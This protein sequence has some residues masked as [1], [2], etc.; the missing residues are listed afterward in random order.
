MIASSSASTS[1]AATGR[2]ASWRGAAAACRGAW[3]RAAARERATGRR[4]RSTAPPAPAPGGRRSGPRMPRRRHDEPSTHAQTARYCRQRA[5]V[6][7]LGGRAAERE[8]A[9]VPAPGDLPEDAVGRRRARLDDA[10]ARQVA[11]DRAHD[12]L[13]AARVPRERLR[14][15]VVAAAVVGRAGD[16]A[17]DRLERGLLD[18]RALD[19]EDVQALVA[20]RREQQAARGRPVAAR[21][22]RLLVVGL[23]RPG[24]R[25][26]AAPCARRPCR[27]PS[28]TRSSRRRRRRR[29]P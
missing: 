5:R 18:G 14:A 7:F 6:P 15:Q 8:R 27:R 19:E 1:P 23:D 17:G 20:R 16:R 2:C 10:G 9:A 4:R 21:A 24:H 22:A 12:L 11:D 13:V 26:V 3:R 25:L 28:R 29:R